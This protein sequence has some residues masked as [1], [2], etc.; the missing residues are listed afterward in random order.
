MGVQRTPPLSLA[1]KKNWVEAGRDCL[2]EKSEL[3]SRYNVFPVPTGDSK[4]VAPKAARHQQ[5]QEQGSGSSV[6][7]VGVEPWVSLKKTTS[8]LRYLGI[9][10]HQINE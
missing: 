10:I 9:S 2:R 6:P 4:Q 1:E 7:R 3:D 8:Q 5:G